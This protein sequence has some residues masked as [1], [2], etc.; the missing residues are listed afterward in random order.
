MNNDDI[1]ILGA[2]RFTQLIK[3]G[4]WEYVR[5]INISGIVV[6]IPLTDAGEIV[7]VEQ[8][9]IPVDGVTIELPAGLV[10]DE[11]PDE[12]MAEAANRE[13]EE[14][15]GFR[16][17]KLEKLFR[18]P[19]SAGLVAEQPWFYRATE[20]TRVGPGGGVGSEDITVHVQPID[21]IDAWL[22]AQEAAGKIIE[23]KV[24]SG[25]YFALRHFQRQQ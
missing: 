24:Y 4:H 13:L 25:L 17:G 1:E 20:L 8:H 2:G 5:R 23:A 11:D 18:G 3:Q 15:T 12:G 14:E 6:I 16:A 7:L 10:G 9:R 19:P 22:K 21:G